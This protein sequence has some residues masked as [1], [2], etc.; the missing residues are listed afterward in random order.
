MRDLAG[1]IWHSKLRFTWDTP[2]I[3]RAIPVLT[4]YALQTWAK[5][6]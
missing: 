4:K 6:P 3:N 2:G 1:T 5:L